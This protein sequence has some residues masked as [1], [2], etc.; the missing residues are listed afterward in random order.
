MHQTTYLLTVPFEQ[1][2]LPK[3]GELTRQVTVTIGD[4]DRKR[5]LTRIP[6][7]WRVPHSDAF[8]VFQGFFEVQPLSSYEV[9][10]ALLGYYHPP[11]GV[12]GAVFDAVVGRKIAEV[13]IRHLV[14]EVANAIAERPTSSTAAQLG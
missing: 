7:S 14:D 3:A 4:P 8:P 5:A 11:F 2:G 6:V 1:L 10:I 9:Q 12:L 13:T